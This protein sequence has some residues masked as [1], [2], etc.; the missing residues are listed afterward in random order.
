MKELKTQEDLQ[1]MPMLQ[2]LLIN[3]VSCIYQEASD[4]SITSLWREYNLLKD[5]NE[6]HLLFEQE[7]IDSPLHWIES[8]Q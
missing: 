6:L 5:N 4:Y 8:G 7:Y 1:Y 2:A 3:Y